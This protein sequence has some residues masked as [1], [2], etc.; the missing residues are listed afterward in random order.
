MLLLSAK[1]FKA[2]CEWWAGFCRRFRLSMRIACN[3]KSG[4]DEDRFAEVM[5]FHV[6][7][8][9]LLRSTEGDPGYDKRFGRFPLKCRWNA[10]ELGNFMLFFLIRV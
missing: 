8:R 3:N 2:S 10:D 9:L 7:L 1:E 6:G 5:R 4:A